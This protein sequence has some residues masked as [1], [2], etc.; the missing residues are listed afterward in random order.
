MYND[1]L[2]NINKENFLHCK[3]ENFSVPNIAFF[4]RG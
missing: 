3:I 2:D 1:I 4:Q